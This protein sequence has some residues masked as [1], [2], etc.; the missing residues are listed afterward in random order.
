VKQMQNLNQILPDIT[1]D[2]IMDITT[3]IMGITIIIT[4]TT[5]I[6][7]KMIM[8]TEDNQAVLK[9]KFS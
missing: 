9:L 6:M 5:I 2:M 3:M 4:D 7:T 8:M 1:M